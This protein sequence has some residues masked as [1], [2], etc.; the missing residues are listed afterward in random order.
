MLIAERHLGHRE[1]SELASRLAE[2]DA[3]RVVLSDTDRRRSHVRTETRDGRELGIAVGRV[4]G[5]GAV[6]ETESGALVVVELE[7]IE[8]LVIGFD[9]SDVTAT[10][11][12]E[13]GHAIGN[14]H[15]EL[16]VRGTEALIRGEESLERM[17]AALSESL[18]ADVTV[19]HERVLPT[20]F[21]ETPAPHD[22]GDGHAHAHAHSHGS[23]R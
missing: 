14:H 10:A 11:A 9:G 7:P 17:E 2:T 4:L 15:W 23:D 16:S 18:P 5:D 21:D 12:L 6:L 13:L 22:H 20:T 19:R 3:H 8:V 1:D